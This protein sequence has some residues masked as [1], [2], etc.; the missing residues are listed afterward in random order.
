MA[1]AATSIAPGSNSDSPTALGAPGD[2]ADWYSYWHKLIDEDEAGGF[3]DLKP[4]TLQK[5]RELGTG[6]RFVRI[7]ARCIKYRRIDL[8]EWSEARLRTSTSDTGA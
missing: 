3:V 4:R 7:S 8:R 6:P 5:Y 1:E 2:A